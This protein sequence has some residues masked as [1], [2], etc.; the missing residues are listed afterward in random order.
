MNRCSRFIRPD[1]RARDLTRQL[2]A[3][4]RKQVLEMQV[5]DLNAVVRGFEKLLRRVIGEDIELRLVL[6]AQ[7]L[8]GQ[9]GHL[10]IGAGADEPGGQRPGRHAGRRNP[11]HRDDRGQ[12]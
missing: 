2:L 10:P 11:D 7:P 3:F 9:G 12:P 5:V 4:S 6:T 8:A 1:L